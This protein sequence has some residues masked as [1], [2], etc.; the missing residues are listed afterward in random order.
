MLRSKYS[1]QEM[2]YLRF[3]KYIITVARP[4]IS[5]SEEEGLA[6]NTNPHSLLYRKA[7]Q[8]RS[9]R[10]N[11]FTRS[12]KCHS[13]CSYGNRLL[14]GNLKDFLNLKGALEQALNY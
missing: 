6:L 10:I 8:A 14:T 13:S 3:W 2:E 12:F 7:I 4:L 5:I 11:L 1:G 9:Y